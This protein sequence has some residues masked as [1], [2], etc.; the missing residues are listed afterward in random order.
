MLSLLKQTV[1]PK[2]IRLKIDT[3]F[4]LIV[5]LV[6]LTNNKLKTL[7]KNG[8]LYKTSFVIFVVMLHLKHV[9]NIDYYKYYIE[10][11]YEKNI[12]G[13]CNI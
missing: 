7:A 11:I 13:S 4:L 5:H 2:T 6:K 10:K 3:K 8:K 12:T 9:N 1:V